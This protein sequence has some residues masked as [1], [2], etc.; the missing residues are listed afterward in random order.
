MMVHEFQAKELLS[1]YGLVS[2]GGKV[3]ITGQ[4]AENIARGFS[5]GSI[6]VKAQVHA[7]GRGRAGGV[8]VVNSPEQA[9][10]AA[11]KMLG[12]RLV[13]DQTGPLGRMTKRVY[14]ERAIQARRELMIALLVDTTTAEFVVIGSASG[15]DDMEERALRGELKLERLPLRRDTEPSTGEIAAFAAALRL[16]GATQDAFCHLLLNL[17]RT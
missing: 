13:T 2:P 11:E 14:I 1:C 12:Q 6:V 9:K 15:G 5:S 8:I 16:D 4:E 3:A 17:R 10:S 7:G